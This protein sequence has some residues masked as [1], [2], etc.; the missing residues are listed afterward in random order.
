MCTQK[1][2]AEPRGG[3]TAP[4][5]R[6][7]AL[8][9]MRYF[10]YLGPHSIL[11]TKSSLAR[12]RLVDF[13]GE[14][15][16]RCK[17]NHASRKESKDKC[18]VLGE[19]YIL[20]PWR[21][22]YEVEP[23]P[24][25]GRNAAEPITNHEL[26]SQEKG[27]PKSLYAQE[28]APLPLERSVPESSRGSSRKSTNRCKYDGMLLHTSFC[29][30]LVCQPKI[31]QNC[32]KKNIII[33]V[34]LREVQYDETLNTEVALPVAPSIHNTRRGPW[35]IQEAFSSCMGTPQFL[36]DFKIKLPLVLG[37][38][39][40]KRYG[41]LFTLYHFKILKKKRRGSLVS[42]RGGTGKPESDYSVEQIGSGFLPLA[43][44]NSPTCLIANGDHEVPINYR[45]VCLDDGED[46][47][48]SPSSTSKHKKKLSFDT[49]GRHARSWSSSSESQMSK[50]G[51]EGTTPAST[52]EHYPEGSLALTCLH[53]QAPHESGDDA[54][55]DN[56]TAQEEDDAS[57]PST[58]GSSMHQRLRSAL[59][60]GD[61]K[62]LGS[63]ANGGK[64]SLEAEMILKVTIVA[65][66]SVH[67]QNKTLA[68][69]FITKPMLPRCL[70]SSDFTE[71]Y[72]PWGKSRSEILYRLK[73]ERIPPFMCVGGYLAETERKLLEPVVSLTKSSK[74][75]HSDVSNRSLFV[76]SLFINLKC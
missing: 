9:V 27:T 50:A 35:L 72:A 5:T 3:K 41:L 7:H 28:V 20:P 74:C 22:Q 65:F 46:M 75:P 40:Q 13:Q 62:S 48:S 34:Q 58:G 24:F 60:S 61:L 14:L 37:A 16:L 49:I 17:G 36:D 64:D 71:A 56:Q 52:D 26:K 69:L 59:S 11:K 38:C 42:S 53:V 21:S 47:E 68:E 4:M 57:L 2:R 63:Q 31:I 44:E 43:L 76:D 54:Q 39:G 10:G 30:E 29:N 73:P 32:S 23:A 33:K 70:V 51:N 18:P 8:L 6:G 55:E 19:N 67:P 15:Q 25:G 12:E 1:Y 66:S 45:A